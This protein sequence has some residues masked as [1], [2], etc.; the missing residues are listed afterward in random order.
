MLSDPTKAIGA[1]YEVLRDPADPF[2]DFPQ[3]ISYLIRPDGTIEKAYQVA[4]PGGHASVV[5]ADLAAAQ[6]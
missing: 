4:D 2:A 6:R 3:R 5:L 1:D